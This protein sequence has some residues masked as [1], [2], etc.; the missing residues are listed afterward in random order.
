MNYVVFYNIY[1][2][3]CPHKHP[4]P[5]PGP[6]RFSNTIVVSM[7]PMVAMIPIDS[8]FLSFSFLLNEEGGNFLF[9]LLR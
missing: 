4:N 5:R 8:S 3:F 7:R 2:K 9:S 6:G 1:H